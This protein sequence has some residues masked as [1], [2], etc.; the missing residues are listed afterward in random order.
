MKVVGYVLAAPITCFLT[1]SWW[2]IIAAHR[3]SPYVPYRRQLVRV[4]VLLVL[5]VLQAF[6]SHAES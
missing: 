3:I 5:L 6:P 1:K 2:G 4:A